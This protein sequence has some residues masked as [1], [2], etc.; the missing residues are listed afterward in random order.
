MY[1]TTGVR[2]IIKGTVSRDILLLVFVKGQFAPK[3][4]IIPLG[5]F[6]I[7]SKIR[8]YSQVKV[9]HRYQRHRRQILPPVLLVLLIPVTN[10]PPVATIPA[11]NCAGFNNTGGK[12]PPVSTTPA[13]NY[14]NNIRLHT[15]LSEL[16]GKNL[17]IC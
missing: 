4:Q 15:P 16:K 9:H 17:Y 5:P 1:C 8:R 2:G 14:G 7:F 13:A 10:L 11:A 12:L 6:R 3:P